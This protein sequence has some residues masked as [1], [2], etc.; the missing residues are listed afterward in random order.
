MKKNCFFLLFP[1]IFLLISCS[2]VPSANEDKQVEL[3]QLSEMNIILYEGQTFQVIPT[4]LPSDAANQDLI[5]SA[6]SPDVCTVENGVITAVSE[7]VSTVTAKAENGVASSLKVQVEK[8]GDIDS[9]RFTEILVPLEVGETHKLNAVSTPSSAS[10]DIPLTWSSSDASVA[11]V[12]SSGR[13]TANGEG[14]CFIYADVKDFLRAVC[15]IR[16]GGD[17]EADLS[18]LVDI[19]VRDLPKSFERKDVNGKV[20]TGIELT[21]Y[22]VQRELTAD[23]VTVTVLINGTKTYDHEGEDAENMV[24]VFMNL[25]ME[26][27]QH[28]ARWTLKTNSVSVGEEFYFEFAFN[29]VQKPYQRQFYIT[30]SESRSDSAE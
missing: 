26:E 10:D 24:R 27:D 21:S 25:F 7:G 15:E 6:S 14:A 23:G 30:L 28:C 17:Y 19:S 4:I 22:E 13:V 12:D 29:A 1:L 8:I 16:V 2:D 20:I 18:E 9:I 3:I 11:S 5:W